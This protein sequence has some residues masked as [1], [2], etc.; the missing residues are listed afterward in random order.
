MREV[1]P[2]FHCFDEN[3][4]LPAAVSFDSMLRHASPEYDYEIFVAGS[5]S[6]LSQNR[7]VEIV[8]Q[9]PNASLRFLDLNYDFLR[10]FESTKNKS[11][12]SK[13]IFAKFLVPDLL[14]N[15][16]KAI[17]TDVDVVWL[18]DISLVWREAGS[19]GPDYLAGIRGIRPPT[20]NRLEKYRRLYE[21]DFSQDEI[22]CLLTGA[23]LWVLNL[24]LMRRDDIPRL[25]YD[26]S[27]KNAHRLR[28]PEQDVINLVTA[29]RQKFL[30]PRMMVCSYLYDLYPDIDSA[31]NDTRY[32]PSEMRDAY[33]RPVQL[34]YAG[35]R[36]PWKYPSV[37]ASYHWVQALARTP[38]L[39]DWLS[40]MQRRLD[41]PRSGDVA[42]QTIAG[43]VRRTLGEPV[44][45][46]VRSFI[47]KVGANH[48]LK[49]FK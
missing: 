6:Q 22:A 9:Y 38:F 47:R 34:H 15:Y 1:I 35:G 23:G 29:P 10:L 45:R 43:K 14:P 12:Y 37:T 40:E 33:L 49:I 24:E 30:S 17:V 46:K 5:I 36:K 44:T 18:D 2:I 19:L 48:V 16:F 26:Y 21:E 8:S 39:E 28:Q 41:D 31:V 13:E 32:S 3:Y 25:A 42:V 11:H 7:L 20:P 27:I 4:V